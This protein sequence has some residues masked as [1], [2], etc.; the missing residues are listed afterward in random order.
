MSELLI[1]TTFVARILILVFEYALLILFILYLY[2]EIRQSSYENKIDK[3]KEKKKKAN[4][5]FYK[6]TSHVD[7][8]LFSDSEEYYNEYKEKETKL[9]NEVEVYDNEIEKY[10]KKSS[11]L[12]AWSS[13]LMTTLICLIFIVLLLIYYVGN[14]IGGSVGD[15][16]LIENNI[17]QDISITAYYEVEYEGVSQKTL[18]VFVRND[19]QNTL[20]NAQLKE[21][22]T[23]N[24]TNVN[25]LEPGEEKIVS[26]NVYSSKES[27]YEFEL[28]NIEFKE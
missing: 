18:T 11:R 3:C 28:S 19:S 20:Q 22:T 10:D 17:N 13:T 8:N 26:I 15:I 27:N 9:K 16:I 24:T 23:G 1:E 4:D 14:C 6:E 7:Y 25:S 21:K 12:N 5:D 2:R